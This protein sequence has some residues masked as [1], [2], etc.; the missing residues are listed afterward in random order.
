MHTSM[1]LSSE[2]HN[3]HTDLGLWREAGTRTDDW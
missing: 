3:E 2:H 1:E